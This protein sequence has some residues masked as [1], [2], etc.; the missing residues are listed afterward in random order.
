MNLGVYFE[1]WEQS[2]A[3]AAAMQARQLSFE[4]RLRDAPVEPLFDVLPLEKRRAA[5]VVEIRC[6]HDGFDASRS[7]RLRPSA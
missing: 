5:E 2:P 3:R 4:R 6:V 7:T 1:G